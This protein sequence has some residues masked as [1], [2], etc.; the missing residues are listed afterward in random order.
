MV[1]H[2]GNNSAVSSASKITTP[3]ADDRANQTAFHALKRRAEEAS[4]PAPDPRA[5]Q[6]WVEQEIERVQDHPVGDR[7]TDAKKADLVRRLGVVRNNIASGS[8]VPDGPT[9]FAWRNL[10][11]YTHMVVAARAAE[12]DDLTDPPTTPTPDPVSGHATNCPECGR[13][14]GPSHVCEAAKSVTLNVGAARPEVGRSEKT[15]P[16]G[17][18][19]G[20]TSVP[21]Q[22]RQGTEQEQAAATELLAVAHV[23]HQDAITNPNVSHR[24]AQERYERA[25]SHFVK[26]T[27]GKNPV[28]ALHTA[29]D[30]SRVSADDVD[31]ARNAAKKAAARARS[32]DAAPGDA[33][34]AQDATEAHMQVC[35]A[36]DTTPEGRCRLRVE[37]GKA[38]ESGNSAR[39]KDL[40]RRAYRAERFTSE[41]QAAASDDVAVRERIE[42]RAVYEDR[43][44]LLRAAQSR[45][46]VR[47][48]RESSMAVQSAREGAQRAREVFYRSIPTP[49]PGPELAS[50]D[51]WA[52]SPPAGVTR[53]DWWGATEWRARVSDGEQ[54]RSGVLRPERAQSRI[55]A[56]HQARQ[57]IL[58]GEGGGVDPFG[59]A[60]RAGSASGPTARRRSDL[61]Q[62]SG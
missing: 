37:L 34:A 57:G 50:A 32:D 23:D 27:G 56:R 16:S 3:G 59:P 18:S 43:V 1:C 25:V 21:V 52:T 8:S 54:V 26:V 61:V 39:V 44:G 6:S 12:T 41:A 15:V 29:A 58:D 48:S 47:P 45:A 28:G 49:S 9:F 46:K 24:A 36:Y 35:A 51:A 19:A 31:T 14:A 60:G 53:N 33:L 2:T 22:P 38:R 11:E 4:E 17:G 20:S 30:G 5:V 13:W 7:L 55:E 10:R 42:L 40:E 62:V